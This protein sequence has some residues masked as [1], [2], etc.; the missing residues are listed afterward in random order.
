MRKGMIICTALKA[1]EK[2]AN[3]LDM[4][5]GEIDGTNPGIFVHFQLREPIILILS[6]RDKTDRSLLLRYWRRSF[7]WC[8]RGYGSP[9]VQ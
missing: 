2:M 8:F 4:I 5:F 1:L 9:P 6:S 7:C 3:L